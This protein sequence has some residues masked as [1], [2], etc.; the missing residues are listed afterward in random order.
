M[1][2]A[3]ARASSGSE[4]VAILGDLVD[5]ELKRTDATAK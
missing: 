2:A 4:S 3:L 1:R 5:R